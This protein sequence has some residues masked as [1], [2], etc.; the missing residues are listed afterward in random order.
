MVMRMSDSRS[1]WLAQFTEVASLHD[2]DAVP[3]VQ[4]AG[5]NVIGISATLEEL[6]EDSLL[7]QTFW[8]NERI[9]IARR[10]S[11]W[12]RQ[13][14]K[15]DRLAAVGHL[16]TGVWELPQDL[17]RNIWWCFRPHAL[18]NLGGASEHLV[19]VGGLQS[20]PVTLS[21]RSRFE[22]IAV[23]VVTLCA[24]KRMAKV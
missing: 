8:G 3:H 10:C 12:V 7:G 18:A 16:L 9:A 21:L 13:G 4:A 15:V 22:Q 14:D 6:H 20:E 5:I 11:F 24:T 2:A 1:I 19:E 17:S 23:T